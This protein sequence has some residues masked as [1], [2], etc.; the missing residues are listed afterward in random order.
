MFKKLSIL[1][2]LAMIL[3]SITLHKP[4]EAASLKQG[5]TGTA[6]TDLQYRLAILGY[7]GYKIVPYYG[8]VTTNA[9][10]KF[11]KN[12]GLSADGI[13]GSR[14]MHAL[15]KV[16]ASKKEVSQLA[17]V[18]YAEAR[19]ESYTGQVA[20]G[21]VIMNRVQSSV[22]P[23]SVNGVIFE[24]N[25]FSVVNNGQYWLMPNATAFKAAKAAA[26]G[27]DPSKGALYFYAKSEAGSAWTKSLHVTVKIG[28][29]VFAK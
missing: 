14:T 7:Y 21:A 17:R 20:V 16:S 10:M 5:S 23:N 3:T 19:G 25:A 12:A 24:P 6:V 9:V 8:S 4:A 26:T 1:F 28:N 29:H 11:Q 27:S 15:K 18:I 2:T 13:A 22:F